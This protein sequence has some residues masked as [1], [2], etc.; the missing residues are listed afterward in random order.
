MK[1]FMR[2]KAE[3]EHTHS[4]SYYQ[5]EFG[6]G[7]PVFVWG[8]VNEIKIDTDGVWYTV[9]LRNTKETVSVLPMTISTLP[10]TIHGTEVFPTGMKMNGEEGIK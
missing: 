7:D 10:I 6:I 5:P 1:G 8:T 2:K 4:A 3:N 9:R